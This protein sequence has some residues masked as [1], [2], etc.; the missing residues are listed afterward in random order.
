V[1]CP[2]GISGVIEEKTENLA[3]G[4]RSPAQDL[5]PTPLEYKAGNLTTIKIS[6]NSRFKMESWE[7]KYLNRHGRLYWI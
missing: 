7:V 5:N 1:R 6:L 2:P 4:S 3:Q